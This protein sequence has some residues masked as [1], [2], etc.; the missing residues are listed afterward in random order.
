M[1]APVFCPECGARVPSHAT[2]IVAARVAHRRALQSFYVAL[3]LLSGVVLVRLMDWSEDT[4]QPSPAAVAPAVSIQPTIE[5][6]A[7]IEW[8][9]ATAT[10]TPVPTATVKPTPLSM[11]DIYGVCGQHTEPGDICYQFRTA[12]TSTPII[13]PTCELGGDWD[14]LCIMQANDGNRSGTKPNE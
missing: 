9:T 3:A 6:R 2:D 7:V 13:F 4:P 8:P 12:P 5:V 1:T 10:A 14:G 11:A